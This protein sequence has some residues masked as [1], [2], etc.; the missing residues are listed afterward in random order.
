MDEAPEAPAALPRAPRADRR[1]RLR[2]GPAAGRLRSGGCASWMHL[3]GVPCGY[4]SLVWADAGYVAGS[5][6][7]LR[8][9][10]TLTAVRACRAVLEL[11][12]SVRMT[13]SLTLIVAYSDNRAIGRD[14]A[15]PWR[16]PGIWRISSAARWAIPSSWGARPGIRWGGRCRGAP[17][18]SS[19]AIRISRRKAPSWWRRWKRPRRPAA[20]SPGLRHRRR[21]D[22]CAGPAAGAP[23]AGHRG[24]C[25]GRGRRLLPAAAGLPMEGARERQPAENGYEY[26]FVT[27]E[28]A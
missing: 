6:V 7:G 17:T 4:A 27:Y 26:D 12:H 20:M 23:R 21:A 15:L 5:R 18:S 19:A 11:R 28:R 13:P 8:G 2:S 1:S 10:A 14:N 25:P 22:L 24:A 9:F 16:L 3:T